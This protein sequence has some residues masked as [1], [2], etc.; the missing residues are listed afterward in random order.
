MPRPLRIYNTSDLREMTDEEIKSKIVP[1]ILKNWATL[2]THTR[3]DII[4]D[5]NT[6]NI[7]SV[8]DRERAGGNIGSHPVSGS[9]S[10]TNRGGLNQNKNTISYSVDSFLHSESSSNLKDINEAGLQS[11]ILRCCAEVWGNVGTNTG[12]GSY[13]LNQNNPSGSFGGTWEKVSVSSGTNS[14]YED[15]DSSGRTWY[16]WRKTH[17]TYPGA[18]GNVEQTT[19]QYIPV[20]TKG[21]GGDII[22]MTDANI[23]TWVNAWRTYIT[24]GT[25]GNGVGTYILKLGGAPS[26]GSWTM[27]G[28]YEDILR[29]VANQAYTGYY[30]GAFTGYYILY[31]SGVN[32]GAYAGTYNGP[33]THYY[34]GLTIQSSNV[35]N[36]YNF[37]RR[38]G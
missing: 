3:G 10:S 32:H 25:G 22:Q 6:P 9:Y 15:D 34:T 14:F 5:H 11:D 31:Y 35:T 24:D 19:S 8:S 28:V 38:I 30:T 27:M 17:G 2:D 1:L 20:K 26:T 33:R 29:D 21:T 16:L 7:G 23:L 12:V 36:H 4:I 37:F 18:T 13:A